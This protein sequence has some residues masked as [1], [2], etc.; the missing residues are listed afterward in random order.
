[1]SCLPDYD[2]EHEIDRTLQPIVV[3]SHWWFHRTT[4][5]H[6]RPVKLRASTGLPGDVEPETK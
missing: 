5:D 4:R 3:G 1:M 6:W 2:Y